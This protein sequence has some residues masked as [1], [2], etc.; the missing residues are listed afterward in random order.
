[1]V[2][3]IAALCSVGSAV[4]FNMK[5][6]A[7]QLLGGVAIVLLLASLGLMAQGFRVRSEILLKRRSEQKSLWKRKSDD[8]ILVIIT[9]A[10]TF[11]A[12]LL[13]TWAAGILQL[14][15]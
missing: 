10:L 3:A 1:M 5:G 8:I 14:F 6:L 11:V 7:E 2:L 13:G 9:A 12:T 15:R 4:M